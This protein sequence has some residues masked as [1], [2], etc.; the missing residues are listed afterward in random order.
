MVTALVAMGA[1]ALIVQ[2]GIARSAGFGCWRRLRLEDDP[3]GLS[4]PRQMAARG[5]AVAAAW[6]SGRSGSAVQLETTERR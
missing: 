1:G 5:A 6:H 4:V 2:R 3:F